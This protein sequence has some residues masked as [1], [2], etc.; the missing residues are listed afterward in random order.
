MDPSFP[1]WFALVALKP[2]S[3]LLA[4]R[5]TAVETLAATETRAGLLSLVRAARGSSGDTAAAVKAVRDADESFQVHNSDAE[6]RVLSTVAIAEIMK[7][8]SCEADFVAL[9]VVCAAFS[10]AGPDALAQRAAEVGRAYLA[11]EGARVRAVTSIS[12]SKVEDFESAASAFSAAA[13][14][15]V[16]GLKAKTSALIGDVTKIHAEAIAALHSAMKAMR[17]ESD[18]L[19]WSFAGY[20]S[21]LDRPLRDVGLAPS[22]LIAAKELADLTRLLPGPRS[23][24]ALLDRT[25][26]Q[27]DGSTARLALADAVNAVDRAWR[28]AWTKAY[29]VSELRELAPVMYATTR[30]LETDSPTDW[31]SAFAKGTG[32]KDAAAPPPA[33]ALQA[34]NENLLVRALATINA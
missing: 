4:K 19:W 31:I 24:V 29:A 21:D 14:T 25:L 33:L 6:L 10:T 7:T 34:Y 1:D 23:A 22:C 16:E 30:S 12:G 32:I 26:A 18:M 15:D 9:A 28:T 2:S 3:D 8:P 13:P 5:W 27:I 20:S 17:E 11:H